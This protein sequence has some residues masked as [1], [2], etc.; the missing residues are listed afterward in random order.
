MI[1]LINYYFADSMI[2]LFINTPINRNS[3]NTFQKGFR[4]HNDFWDVSN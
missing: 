2:S 1:D 4:T 3:E